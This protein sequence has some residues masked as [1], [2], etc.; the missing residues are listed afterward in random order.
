MIDKYWHM[1]GITI[2]SFI[3]HDIHRN[4]LDSNDDEAVKSAAATSKVKHF[5]FN[6]GLL[7]IYVYRRNH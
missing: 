6:Q 2:H 4:I 1:S 7:L 5:V 3:L